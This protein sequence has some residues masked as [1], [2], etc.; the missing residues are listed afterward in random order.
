M[1]N[2]DLPLIPIKNQILV[3]RSPHIKGSL[4]DSVLLMHYVVKLSHT[5]MK[6]P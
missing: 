1:K 4:R 3:I 2:N 5:K 6:F